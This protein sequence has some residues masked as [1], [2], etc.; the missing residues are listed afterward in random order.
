MPNN[1]MRRVAMT[2][3]NVMLDAFP[4]EY[5]DFVFAGLLDPGDVVETIIFNLIKKAYDEKEEK[6][7]MRYTQYRGL[8]Q[9]TRFFFKLCVKSKIRYK[10]AK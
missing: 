4:R 3:L 10:K 9:V 1:K 5:L 6:H 7:S 8:S 2:V